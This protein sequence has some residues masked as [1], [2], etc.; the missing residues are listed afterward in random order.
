MEYLEY[1]AAHRAPGDEGLFKPDLAEPVLR[2]SMEVFID[3]IIEDQRGADKARGI[4]TD[5]AALQA[6]VDAIC[7][8]PDSWAITDKRLDTYRKVI[9]P[10][11]DLRRDPLLSLS[12]KKDGGIYDLL[13]KTVLEY[14]SGNQT[15]KACL[16]GLQTLV[17]E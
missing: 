15:L 10:H 4:C 8:A 14:V 5:E 9:L 7:A 3:F 17:N 2:P 16:D 11:L 6:Q 12:S 1:I 13:L